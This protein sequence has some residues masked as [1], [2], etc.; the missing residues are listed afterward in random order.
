M[1]RLLSIL[2]LSS[3]VLVLFLV[4]VMSDCKSFTNIDSPIVK[5]INSHLVGPLKD[6]DQTFKLKEMDIGNSFLF[7]Y[8]F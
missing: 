1:T 2:S 4:L 7:G 8:L 6:I 3:G 5:V